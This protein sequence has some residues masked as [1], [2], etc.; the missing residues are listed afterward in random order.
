MEDH[1]PISDKS[2][3]QILSLHFA[4]IFLFL[5]FLMNDM[6]NSSAKSSFTLGPK[7][8]LLSKNLY[9]I[10]EKVLT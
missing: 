9:T 10:L 3:F 7:P 5:N 1:D 4:Y 2:A 8:V 6:Y